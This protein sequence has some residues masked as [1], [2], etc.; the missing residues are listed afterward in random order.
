[1][2]RALSNDSASEGLVGRGGGWVFISI[3]ARRTMGAGKMS[4]RSR[5]TGVDGPNFPRAEKAE[6]FNSASKYLK[7]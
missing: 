3:T 7:I 1:M 2:A 5:G 4:I 6:F